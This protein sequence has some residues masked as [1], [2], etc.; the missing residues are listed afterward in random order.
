MLIA[1]EA[2]TNERFFIFGFATKFKK[3]CDVKREKCIVETI[4]SPS[5]RFYADMYVAD[6]VS[7]QISFL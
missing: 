5:R 3:E 7:F 6:R 4:F 2:C 1:Y